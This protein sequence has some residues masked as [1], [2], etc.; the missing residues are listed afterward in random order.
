M[1]LDDYYKT[2]FK[3]P[4][5]KVVTS[6]N[7]NS[8][9]GY[10]ECSNEEST[11]RPRFPVCAS[12]KHTRYC[13]STPYTHDARD[14]IFGHLLIW[15]SVARAS[16][17]ASIK[18]P[19]GSRIKHSAGSTKRAMKLRESALRS[20]SS[21]ITK[22]LTISLRISFICTNQHSMSLL[23]LFIMITLPRCWL[24]TRISQGLL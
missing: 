9:C 6:R 15:G 10:A 2:V 21:R 24:S 18:S 8:P 20:A 7:K 23:T 16:S 17:R 4:S 22:S 13:V 11:G 19:H 3:S 1:P 14:V 5:T 12:C